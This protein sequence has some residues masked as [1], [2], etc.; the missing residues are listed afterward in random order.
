MKPGATGS[1]PRARHHRHLA[2]TRERG[3]AAGEAL[4]D[5]FLPVAQA[6]EF[7]LRRAEGDAMRGHRLGFVD[8][9]G[10]MQQRLGG[11][12]A[13]IEADA[14]QRRAL[15]DQHDLLSEVRGPE[16]GGV[17]AGAGAEHEHVAIEICSRGR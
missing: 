17:A 13:D 1:E 15:V 12:A 2:L 9:L 14:A 6:G 16:R 5:A 4:D 8:D 7:D 11:D 3:Q 10:H